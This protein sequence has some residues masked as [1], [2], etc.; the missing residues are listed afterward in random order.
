[1]LYTLIFIIFFKFKRVILLLNKIKFKKIQLI[2]GKKN[3]FFKKKYNVKTLIS[4]RLSI[5]L[6]KRKKQ[7]YKNNFSRKVDSGNFFFK[8]FFYKTL[9]KN[10]KFLKPFLFSNSKVRQ[11][12]ISRLIFKTSKNKYQNSNNEYTLLNVLLR[13]HFFFFINDAI[14]FINSGMVYV[15]G[16]IY[17]NPHINLN[18]GDCIQLAPC[19]TFYSYLYFCKKFFKKKASIFRFNS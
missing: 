13:S 16:L 10:R 14:K 4:K 1:M 18:Q 19:K 7:L 2:N 11:S 6:K 15:N 17:T 12:R 8:K 5:V 3:L 9:L